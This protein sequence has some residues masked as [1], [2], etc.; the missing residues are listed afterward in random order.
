M[1]SVSVSK[2]T[3]LSLNPSTP[4]TCS[5]T[6]PVG[7]AAQLMLTTR[8][9]CLLIV[10]D[11]DNGDLLGIIT[12]KDLAFRGNDIYDSAGTIVTV[13]DI[14]TPNPLCATTRTKAGDAL[15]LM[16]SK[17]F[18]HLPV[19]DAQTGVIVGVLEITKC[20]NVAM[21][22]LEKLYDE[23]K[24]F[25]GAVEIVNKEL[26]GG[27]SIRGSA[28]IIGYFESLRK[29]LEG[30]R[31]EELLQD[32]STMPVYCEGSASVYDV[33]QLMR[34]KKI[35][36]V[37][38]RGGGDATGDDGAGDGVV[39]I[40]TSKDVVSRV[41]GHGLDPRTCRVADVMTKHPKS[42]GS[43][44]SINSAL[45]QMFQGKYMNLPVV[46]EQ[47]EDIVGVVDIIRLTHYALSQ[48]Q[49]M[50]TLAE[51]GEMDDAEVDEKGDENEPEF[52]KF[53]ETLGDGEEY[54]GE[55][56]ETV[57]DVSMDEISQFDMSYRSAKSSGLG[58]GPK[59][60]NS[61]LS[62]AAVDYDD[63]CFFKFTVSGGRTHRVSYCP[64]DGIKGFK[65]LLREELGDDVFEFEITYSDEDEDVISVKTDR[66]L[67]D[68]LLLMKSLGREKVD[69][70]LYNANEV[71][72]GKKGKMQ[73][74]NHNGHG[75]RNDNG[76][77]WLLP[78]SMFT[79]A[80]TIAIVAVVGMR[81]K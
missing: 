73:Q 62:M 72:V 38:V 4:V 5:A 10:D 52:N 37:L 61:L 29:L 7:K 40:I 39:G 11:G 36:A 51:D 6:T 76:N 19:V 28:P 13:G 56:D 24:R 31:L 78:L 58:R 12:S 66:D 75:H 47:G 1:S 34:S 45:K 17:K 81:R 9:N 32:D 70:V 21:K 80:G 44:M 14:M 42:A 55:G 25:Y 16:V 41:I 60:M 18:R 8:E 30:P 20:Y 23:S 49:T 43:K 48:I 46:E 64:S 54:D 68:C 26:A 65:Q 35:T 33:A 63:V 69:L 59:R 57:G 2:G 79:L 22:R 77:G 27:K 50:E 67:K 71:I 53:L 15:K 74:K 3:V